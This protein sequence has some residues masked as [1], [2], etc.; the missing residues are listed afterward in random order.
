MLDKNGTFEKCWA[1]GKS[2][3]ALKIQKKT[4]KIRKNVNIEIKKNWP[5]Q[6][7]KKNIE[8]PEKQFDLHLKNEAPPPKQ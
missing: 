6:K 1:V 2:G 5:F 7:I 3:K 4:L 8:N